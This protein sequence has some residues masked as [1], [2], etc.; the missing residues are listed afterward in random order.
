MASRLRVPNLDTT[1]GA[2]FLGSIFAA[3]LY[4]GVCIQSFIYFRR[5]KTDRIYFRMIIGALWALDSLHLAFVTHALYYYLIKSYS[6]PLALLAPNWSI[7]SQVFVTCISNVTMRAIYCRRVWK[8]SHN[9]FVV[10]LI[11]LT[12]LLTFSSGISFG[13]L[14]WAEGTFARLHNI[15]YLM[16]TSLA[17][18]VAADA[19]IATSICV[20]L[21]RSRTG[22]KK[23]DSMVTVLMLYAINSSECHSSGPLFLSL[24]LI[25]RGLGGLTS[26]CSLACFITYAV[27]PLE[28]IFIAIYFCLSKLFLNSLLA[29]LNG[30]TSLKN[31]V[32][33]VNGDGSFNFSTNLLS[34]LSSQS[35]STK[36]VD[37]PSFAS[38]D[39]YAMDKVPKSPTMT[40]TVNRHVETSSA[41]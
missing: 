15:S 28:F 29:M 33:V 3:I 10:V 31:K 35:A 38:K 19:L 9:I 34:N 27:W 2:A 18:A 13:I 21:S 23:T 16:Y 14:G 17:S 40:I 39:V 32:T 25:L 26:I 22:F 7:M 37:Y 36:A 41:V 5:S 12:T 24:I 1:L 20:S 6:N 8:L 4:G 30:R 11:A